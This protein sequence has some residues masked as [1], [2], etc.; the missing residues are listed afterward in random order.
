MIDKELG[1]FI[2]ELDTKRFGF[3]VARIKEWDTLNPVDVIRYLQNQGVRLVISKVPEEKTSIL[4]S[5]KSLG[6][7]EMDVILHYK[8]AFP[9]TLLDFRFS[10]L[11]F[12]YREAEEDDIPQL[13][14]IAEHSFLGGHYFSDP[15]LDKEKCK[16]IYPDW[17]LRSCLGET[18]DQ[19]YIAYLDNEIAG[20]AT[21][22]I[23]D[24]LTLWAGIGATNKKFRNQ[25]VCRS[26][27]QF[28]I[29]K[30]FN[31]NPFQYFGSAVS[32]SNSSVNKVFLDLGC[33][34]TERFY[35]LH[36]WH[37]QSINQ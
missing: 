16:G 4:H 26:I 20:F 29:N 3:P 8:R 32:E 1:L 33:K 31:N 35:I 34:P 27:L 15:K 37:D 19:V 5:L 10:T 12:E 6:F 9:E 21:F 28:G 18:A 2:S 22:E 17:I 7:D 24:S 14:E 13:Q 23:K 30:Y 36:G 11:E 25:G